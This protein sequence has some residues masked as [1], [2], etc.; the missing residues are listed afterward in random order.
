MRRPQ[1]ALKVDIERPQIGPDVIRIGKDVIELLTSGM[2]LSP[3]TIYREY[4]QN[5]AD[6]VDA[7][8][9]QGLFKKNESGRV[10]I[11]I[12]HNERSVIIRDNGIGLSSRDAPSC[13]V[14]I[15]DSPKRHTRARGFRGVGRLSGLAYCRELEFR[16]K[17]AGETIIT[18]VTWDCRGLRSRLYDGAFDGG[19]RRIIS[20]SVSIWFEDTKDVGAH[21]FEV[22]MRDV[23]RHRQDLL[24][25]EKIVREYL[26]QVG[27]VGFSPD[28]SF[29]RKIEEK[30]GEF[31][32]RVPLTLAVMGEPVHRPYRD[33]T[34]IPG[35]PHSVN[36][37]EAE[38]FEFANIDGDVSAVG[39]LGH[40]DYVRSIPSGLGIRGLR[41][42]VGDIQIGEATLF[43]EVFKEP[44]FNGWSIGEVHV[45]DRRIVPN[46][47][48]DN[49]EVNH[50]SYNLLAQLAPVAARI[51][52]RCRSSSVSRNTSLIIENAVK[53]IDQHLKEGRRGSRAELSKF[54]S[55]AHRCRSKL[56]A[57]SDPKARARLESRLDRVDEALKT[58][59]PKSK[60][61]IVVLDEALA[62]V[63]K[64]VTNREQ[65]KKLVQEL[66]RICV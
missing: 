40:H 21:F 8:R 25:N 34:R 47:R 66:R 36:I 44:R 59:R 7:A 10:S 46:G 30:L 14:A 2:Y 12:D 37:M 58:Q 33:Q 54:L 53:E 9:D 18:S 52:H 50:H 56:K 49:F 26:A 22:H 6:S 48:R 27:P 62:L 20:D 24:L 57:V 42:R 65:A 19:L 28:Y 29:G 61:T 32:V 39:W 43:D 41:A 4:I 55:T 45:L 23:A 64:H 38:F 13:L 1:P 17:A 35:G 3:V 51:A 5:A 16:T 63:S 60:T 11:D 15:G 31:D